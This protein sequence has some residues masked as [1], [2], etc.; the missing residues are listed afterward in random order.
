MKIIV[1]ADPNENESS[2]HEYDDKLNTN[3]MQTSTQNDHGTAKP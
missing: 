1:H 2:N 3:Q